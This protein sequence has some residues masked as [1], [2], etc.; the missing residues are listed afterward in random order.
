V[1]EPPDVHTRNQTLLCQN[2][3]C[4]K[5]GI[6]ISNLQTHTRRLL[7]IKPSNQLVSVAIVSFKEKFVNCFCRKF[8]KDIV[9]AGNS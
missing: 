7:S 6:E 4:S 9:F 5:S 3:T 1:L 2:K 8:I